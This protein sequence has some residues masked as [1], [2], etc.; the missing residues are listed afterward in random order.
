MQFDTACASLTSFALELLE[1]V[2][3]NLASI[4]AWYN[5]RLGPSDA[6]KRALGEW[7]YDPKEVLQ[8][9][10]TGCERVVVSPQPGHKLQLKR[11]HHDS[12]KTKTKICIAPN[13]YQYLYR[14]AIS[15]LARIVD[16]FLF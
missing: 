3:S 13:T 9:G 4:T 8:I 7:L 5:R 12:Q 11:Q 14:V 1:S 2:S 15:S 6:T 10:H 16:F